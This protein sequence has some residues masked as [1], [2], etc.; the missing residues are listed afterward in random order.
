M[1]QCLLVNGASRSLPTKKRRQVS[2][3]EYI[4]LNRPET[5]T[6]PSTGHH[7]SYPRQSDKGCY[8][9]NDLNPR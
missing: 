1:M 4:S 7:H 5:V 9:L 2:R 3:K 6:A 8:L